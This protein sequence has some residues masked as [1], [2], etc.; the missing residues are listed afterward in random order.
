MWH[1]KRGLEFP[2]LIKCSLTSIIAQL[3][4]FSTGPSSG[5]RGD[6]LYIT[7]L[8]TDFTAH[9]LA[10]AMNG[11]NFY[12]LQ[13]RLQASTLEFNLGAEFQFLGFNC[14]GFLNP[15]KGVTFVGVTSINFLLSIIWACI[16]DILSSWDVWRFRTFAFR[17]SLT[18]SADA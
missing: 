13:Y 16:L 12:L 14:W 1:F 8:A 5:W 10:S 6:R 17:V 4:A 11:L 2:A 7:T 18:L 3:M 9:S 15:V